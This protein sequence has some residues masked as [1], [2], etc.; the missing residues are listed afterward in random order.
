[1]Q[2]FSAEHFYSSLLRFEP[3]RTP[4]EDTARR[5]FAGLRSRRFAS[6]TAWRVRAMVLPCAAA[7]GAGAT[8]VAISVAG[9]EKQAKNHDG[10]TGRMRAPIRQIGCIGD[11]LPRRTRG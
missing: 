6:P 3:D 10:S 8:Q 11:R 2:E 7:R 9:N 4:I 1:M 5:R